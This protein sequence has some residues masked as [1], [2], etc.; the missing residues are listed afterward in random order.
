MILDCL[1]HLLFS[2]SYDFPWLK[3]TIQ[4]DPDE[5]ADYP[6]PQESEVQR[7]KSFSILYF[8]Y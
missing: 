4:Y 1:F 5:E 3:D 6:Q 7:P 2:M 8:L